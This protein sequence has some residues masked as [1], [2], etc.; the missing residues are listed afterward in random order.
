M[1]VIESKDIKARKDH[2]CDYCG[3]KINK[4]EIYT[5]SCVKSDEVYTWK[6]HLSCQ[7]I[8]S[9]LELFDYGEGVTQE[10]FIESVF[11]YLE[12]KE[13]KNLEKA[14]KEIK[15]KLNIE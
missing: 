14:I 1:E 4:N 15:L 11:D 8:A 10:Y 13:Y 7:E 2:V 6:N 9:K 12:Y 3:L 5:R